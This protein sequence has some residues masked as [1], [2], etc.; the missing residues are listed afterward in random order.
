[1]SSIFYAVATKQSRGEWYPWRS[2]FAPDPHG[3]R[4]LYCTQYG[5]FCP[6]ADLAIKRFYVSTKPAPRKAVTNAPH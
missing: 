3:A 4:A 6:K 5:T 1:M 2:T